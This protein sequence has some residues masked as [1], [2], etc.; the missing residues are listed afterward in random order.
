MLKQTVIL[1][2]LLYVSPALGLL[3]DIL[4]IRH[5]GVGEVVDVYRVCLAL[6]LIGSGI[7]AGTL[8]R[9]ALVPQ[10]AAFQS[11]GDLTGGLRFAAVFSGVVFLAV[12]PVGIISIVAPAWILGH[13]APGLSA[14]T[15]T[16]SAP[17]MV[18]AGMGLLLL[19]AVSCANAVLQFFGHYWVST[20]GQIALNGAVVIS[21]VLIDWNP[22]SLAE[23]AYELSLV[24]AAGLAVTCVVSA[25]LLVKQCGDAK[26]WKATR[27]G[28]LKYDL[29]LALVV[30]APQMLIVLSEIVRPIIVN[31]ELSMVSVGSIAMFSYAFRLLMIAH[32]PSLALSTV[33]FPG[34]AKSFADGDLQRVRRMFVKGLMVVATACVVVSVAAS[35]CG[36]VIVGLLFGSADLTERSL[37]DISHLFKILVMGTLA[38]AL[39]Q[40]V[41]QAA[42]A[43][44]QV[45]SVVGY[46]VMALVLVP[47]AVIYGRTIGGINGVAIGYVIIN[48]VLAIAFAVITYLGINRKLKSPDRR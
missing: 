34:F 17:L 24:L 48:T 43:T 7:M 14:E 11:R 29:K 32:L 15:L 21:L 6:M 40:Y 38:G 23:Q 33:V 27:K 36:D 45:R 47:L 2:G 39:V 28:W 26:G 30:I 18:V 19:L 1:T 25:G 41:Q 3:A 4:F 5:F 10:L 13:L 46:S 35:L 9:Y 37:G 42:Y 16:A 12:M 20:V 44:R 22:L 8:L 31:R